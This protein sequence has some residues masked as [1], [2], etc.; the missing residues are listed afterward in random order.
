MKEKM[1]PQ[2]PLSID[3][4]QVIKQIAKLAERE[5]TGGSWNIPKN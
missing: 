1:L 5:C 3:N 4:G 2:K